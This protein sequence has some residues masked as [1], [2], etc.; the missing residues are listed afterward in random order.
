MAT[1]RSIL[2]SGAFSRQQAEALFDLFASRSPAGTVAGQIGVWDGTGYA[3]VGLNT[4]TDA[5]DDAAAA[6]AG[7]AVGGLYRTGSIIKVRVA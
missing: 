4:L 5:A 3:P 7:I 1:L 6:G 2:Q